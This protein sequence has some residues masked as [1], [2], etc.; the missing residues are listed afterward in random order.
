MSVFERQD[1]EAQDELIIRVD[2]YAGPLYALL[3]LAH[4]QKVDLA[5][6]S[7]FALCEQY[8]NFIEKSKALHI[9]QIADYLV[10]AAWLVYLKSRL[11][12]ELSQP[13]EDDDSPVVQELQIKFRRM[14]QKVIRSCAEQLMRRALLGRDVFAR[15]APEPVITDEN[16]KYEVSLYEFLRAYSEHQVRRNAFPWKRPPLEVISVEE[17][18]ELLQMALAHS[19]SECREWLDFRDVLRRC[20]FRYPIPQS[21]CLAS[22]FC[23]ALALAK[24]EEVEIQ[25]ISAFGVLRLR[26]GRS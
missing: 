22:S 6:I 12:L 3:R 21:S 2:G 18:R 16:R 23:A 17:A 7:V 13:R 15:G 20:F 25:Q 19:E 5:Q 26:R 14:R 8:L 11:L 24:E 10:M 1:L 9:E 4:A